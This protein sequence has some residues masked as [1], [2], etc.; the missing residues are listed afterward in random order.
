MPKIK[1]EFEIDTD[2]YTERFER[3][4]TDIE[5]ENIKEYLSD[6]KSVVHYELKSFLE[7]GLHEE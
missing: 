6:L 5:I 3:E 2:D 7:D 1:V 4:F